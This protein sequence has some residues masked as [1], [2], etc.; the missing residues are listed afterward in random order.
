[1]QGI[2]QV[3]TS[4]AQPNTRLEQ[5]FKERPQARRTI[6]AA[7]H[8]VGSQAYD[9]AG[10]LVSLHVHCHCTPYVVGVRSAPCFAN[11]I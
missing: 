6:I 8:G 9:N 2:R 5:F 10:A 11:V 1:M 7:C 3:G 4:R